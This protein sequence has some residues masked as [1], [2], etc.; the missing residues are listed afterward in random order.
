MALIF[1]QNV[2]FETLLRG[3]SNNVDGDELVALGWSGED[4]MA[5]A[6]FLCGFRLAFPPVDV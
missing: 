5:N 1:Q 4:Q 6:L 3:T 2:S